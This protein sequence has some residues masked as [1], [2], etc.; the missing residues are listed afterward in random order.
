MQKAKKK[1]YK[2][3][4]T[5]ELY[6]LVTPAGGKYW[7]FNYRYDRKRKTLALGI[8]PEITLLD[9]RSR[10]LEARK[11]LMQDIDPGQQSQRK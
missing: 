2:I 11:A 10:L 6:L 9:A 4:D 7:H 8:Y 1:Q 3:Q 5:D